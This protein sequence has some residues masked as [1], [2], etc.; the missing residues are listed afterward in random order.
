MSYNFKVRTY[1]KKGDLID[2]LDYPIK[3]GPF[4]IKQI[5]ADKNCVDID[6]IGLVYVDD[7]IQEIARAR[8]RRDALE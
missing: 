7:I 6:G 8:R 5:R 3:S 4:K 1:Y 2:D